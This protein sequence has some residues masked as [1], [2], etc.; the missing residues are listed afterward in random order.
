MTTPLITTAAI[1]AAM[2]DRWRAPEYAIMWEVAAATGAVVTR[3][4][5]AVIMSLWPSRGLELHG[6][7]IKV[8]RSDWRREAADPTKAEQIAAFC[9]RW[10]V[11]TAPG[12]VQDLSEVPPAWGLREWDGK[13]WK[14]RREA[15][16]TEARPLTREFL[17]ALLR[18]A[19]GDDRA[20]IDREVQ[21]QVRASEHAISERVEREVRERM[22][23]REKDKAVLDAFQEATGLDLRGDRFWR[24]AD[25]AKQIG[26]IV[27]ALREAGGP[28]VGYA[29]IGALVAQVREH[30]DALERALAA[31][32]LPH[33]M[34]SDRAKP[35]GRAKKRSLA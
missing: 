12:I 8:S 1:K 31:F 19:D 11:H 29:S 23:G 24:S 14:T 5:D 26:A 30:A 7:E 28:L 22:G 25:E 35:L 16:K 9:D 13:A 10:W 21:A 33:D 3:R 18:R 15:E 2:A 20:R 32:P 6:V 17:A 4:A 27:K 34:P